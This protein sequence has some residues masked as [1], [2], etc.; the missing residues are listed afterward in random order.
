MF[1]QDKP[2]NQCNPSIF[3]ADARCPDV[4]VEY[5]LFVCWYL[6]CLGRKSGFWRR[7]FGQVMGDVYSFKM[8]LLPINMGNS[9]NS[10][11]IY[12]LVCFLSYSYYP[13]MEVFGR[14][15]HVVHG[16]MVPWSWGYLRLKWWLQPGWRSWSPRSP[17]GLIH[18]VGNHLPSGKR[19]HSLHSSWTWPIEI[20][21]LPK[22]VIWPKIVNDSGIDNG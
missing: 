22:M 15:G 18:G 1:L 20:V 19:L 13:T 17:I 16:P 4:V 14:P 5:F 7:K 10:W 9:C 6:G 2:I 11:D 12:F 8:L 21:D 3:L